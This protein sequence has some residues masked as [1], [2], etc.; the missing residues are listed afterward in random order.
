MGFASLNF[1]YHDMSNKTEWYDD[2]SY[3]G[4]NVLTFKILDLFLRPE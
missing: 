2:E 3:E 1:F 4:K